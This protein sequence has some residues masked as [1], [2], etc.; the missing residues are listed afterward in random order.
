MATFCG[1]NCSLNFFLFHVFFGMSVVFH[2]GFEG[3]TVVL[4]K[5]AFFYFFNSNQ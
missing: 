3:E 2:F 4:I 1:K 5:I